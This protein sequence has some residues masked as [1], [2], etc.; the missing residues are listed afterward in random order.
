A[1]RA[2][3]APGIQGR[4]WSHAAAGRG[5]EQGSCGAETFVVGDHRAQ[6]I[7]IG[8]RADGPCIHRS[9]SV[10]VEAKERLERS[11]RRGPST[12]ANR[13][14]TYEAVLRLPL[15]DGVGGDRRGGAGRATWQAQRWVVE[16]RS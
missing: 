7:V 13:W 1:L 2:G 4:G 14:Q 12:S 3:V 10:R 11:L 16:R 8:T 9:R 6:R 15:V 5:C